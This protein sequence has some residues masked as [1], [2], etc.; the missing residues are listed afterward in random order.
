MMLLN[1]IVTL[2]ADRSEPLESVPNRLSRNTNNQLTDKDFRMTSSHRVQGLLCHSS[3]RSRSSLA[4]SAK[5]VIPHR[6]RRRR[7]VTTAE[8]AVHDLNDSADFTGRLEAV[9]SV[10]IRPRV[11]GYVESVHFAEGGRVAAG[12]LLYQIDPRPFKAQVDRLAAERERALAQLKLARVVS[13]SRGTAARAQRDVAGG[14]RAGRRR[15]DASPP[16]SSRRSARRSRRR[17][18]I[19]RSRA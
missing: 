5:P 1:G 8:V 14:V 18:S 16:R 15:C 11:G 4:P 3:C 12:D 19:F 2:E 13:R 9:E 10:A 7:E 6:L 17:S